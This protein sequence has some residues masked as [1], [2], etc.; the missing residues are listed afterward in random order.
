MGKSI[1]GISVAG[2]TYYP[3]PIYTAKLMELY[4]QDENIGTPLENNRFYQISVDNY[5]IDLNS[6]GVNE[7]II[8]KFDNSYRGLLLNSNIGFS[9]SL[10]INIRYDNAPV[11]YIDVNKGDYF[12][13][14][15]R[16]GTVWDIVSMNKQCM[17]I[18]YEDL[19]VLREV[20]GLIPGMKYRIIDYVT[21]DEY[22]NEDARGVLRDL[23]YPFHYSTEHPF[24][25]IVTAESKKT[26]N[27][28]ATAAHSGGRNNYVDTYFDNCDLSKWKLW[29]S[30]D[31][32][33]FN[34]G[35][36][37]GINDDELF[38]ASA[39]EMI[40]WGCNKVK[41]CIPGQMPRGTAKTD[42]Y[43]G[44]Y[45]QQLVFLAPYLNSAEFFLM[46]ENKYPGAIRVT[47]ITE[48]S[49]TT[50]TTYTLTM[51]TGNTYS[52]LPGVI[53]T[54]GN[55][56][57]SV[58]D[59]VIFYCTEVGRLISV[60]IST[61]EITT[62]DVAGT[63]NITSAQ[64]LK[65][66]KGVI[67]RMIDEWG[68]DAPYDFKN[69]VSYT[70]AFNYPSHTFG[71]DIN[72]D[73]VRD[74]SLNGS[75]WGN[76]I[77][78][79]INT[80]GKPS[81]PYISIGGDYQGA[82]NCYIGNNAYS[83]YIPV[84]CHD[85]KL[86]NN[87]S[88]IRLGTSSSS[89][90]YDINIGNT[91]TA[92]SLDNEYDMYNITIG[93]YCMDTH[94]SGGDDN[95][96]NINIGDICRNIDITGGYD[97]N[98]GNNCFNINVDSNIE[99]GHGCRS[100]TCDYDCSFGCDCYNITCGYGNTFGNGC[101]TNTCGYN[102]VFGGNCY[103]ITCGNSNVFGNYC[104]QIRMASNSSFNVFGNSCQNI[105]S[106]EYCNYNL[107]GN[108]VGY[109]VFAKARKSSTDASNLRGY[110]QYNVLHDGVR[111]VV[112]YSTTTP[113]DSA[114]LR[115]VHIDT[116]ATYARTSY[117]YTGASGTTGVS[118]NASVIQ[119]YKFTSSDVIYTLA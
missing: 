55:P 96:Y 89:Y 76:T 58:S 118:I 79:Y 5:P 117:K 103:N 41:T 31:C 62:L 26:L 107:F 44:R 92:I 95:M 47:S 104:R 71:Y 113:S 83:I 67:Y 106:G 17:D 9:D 32:D 102:N 81:I 18:L 51:S 114:I 73:G 97:V 88:V 33:D 101:S 99:I 38:R 87:C 15:N 25:I 40:F 90:L 70:P 112:I 14:I 78:Q 84:M 61:R 65:Q 37:L 64:S 13:L 75:A 2:E 7:S 8:I 74:Y 12:E 10:T 77:G 48:Q 108:Y 68:N 63:G 86:G 42:V 6:N 69:I 72:T 21:M 105:Y 46:S 29:Y 16:S 82:R 111:Y 28:I 1:Y 54:G 39:G 116:P 53:T 36:K 100:I 50:G 119:R 93:N 43:V 115:N 109:I 94:I 19:V 98:I 35:Y 56:N 80:A 57:M 60:N 110:C 59:S 3:R 27:P 45:G 30:L 66:T 91:C 34:F 4:V 24:D 20:S 22:C 85:V 52:N 49:L 23:T 11:H